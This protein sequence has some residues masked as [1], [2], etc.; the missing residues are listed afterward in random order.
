MALDPSY[1]TDCEKSTHGSHANQASL[2]LTYRLSK[3]QVR[4]ALIP[5]G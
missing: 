3:H 4:A 5:N 1:L 2:K